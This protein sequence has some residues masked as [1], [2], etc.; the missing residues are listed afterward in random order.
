MRRPT[1]L[2]VAIPHSADSAADPT[3]DEEVITLES[4]FTKTNYRIVA[5]SRGTHSPERLLR[6]LVITQPLVTPTYSVLAAVE[7]SDSRAAY[8][9]VYLT[10]TTVSGGAA[11]GSMLLTVQ[12]DGTPNPF[13]VLDSLRTQF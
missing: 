9:A 13:S 4:F 6:T 7:G 10:A 2:V 5:S 11:I 3:A 12:V 1:D 8:D